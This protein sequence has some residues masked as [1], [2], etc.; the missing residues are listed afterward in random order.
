MH[1]RDLLLD[2]VGPSRV[3]DRSPMVDRAGSRRPGRSHRA[4]A[5]RRDGDSPSSR[6]H[7]TRWSSGASPVNRSSTC[8]ATGRSGISS[9]QV[10]PRVLI[11]RPETEVVVGHALDEL[12]R[13]IDESETQP[14]GSS[15]S[16][17]APVRV[18]SLCRSRSRARSSS[19]TGSWTCGRPTSTQGA[20]SLLQNAQRVARAHEG[21]ARVNLAQGSW[22]DALPEEL[23]GKIALVVSNPPYVSEGE[24]NELDPV[25]RDHE[26]RHALVAGPLGT[27]MIDEIFA[28]APRWLAPGGALVL[29]VAPH[30]ADDAALRAIVSG[31]DAV[32]V[33]QDFAERSRALVAR[34]YGSALL[35]S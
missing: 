17:S 12:R 33:R 23:A 29:E 5:Q 19:A 25:V 7:L 10:D 14:I 3:C 32:V 35:E 9:S 34:Y 13:A 31:F 21:S 24:W 30:Q 6:S 4:G 16:T 11:P 8:S 20:W 28:E 22:F 27:E 18:Q 15:R 1:V 2:I 26:P